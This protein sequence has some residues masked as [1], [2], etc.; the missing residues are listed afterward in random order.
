MINFY[1]NRYKY[2]IISIAIFAV[3]LVMGLIYGVKLDI[4]FQGGSITTYSYEGVL[5]FKKLENDISKALN[6]QVS[7]N[8]AKDIATG[9]N[10]VKIT[11][12][13]SESITLAE[14]EK[15]TKT[16]SEEYKN[17]KITYIDNMNVD[18][19]IGSEFFQKSLVAV[20]LASILI[21]IYVAVRFRKIGGWSAGAMAL[22]ALI[23]DVLIVFSV[24][25]ILRMPLNDNFIAVVLTVLGYS[26][27]DT[28]VI[29]DR[30]RENRR[31]LG[32][33]TKVVE[34]VNT[35]M[36]ET[37]SRT[38]NTSLSTFI[39]VSTVVVFSFIFNLESIRSFAI[40]MAAG[41]ISGAY[42]TLCIACTL[43]MMYKNREEKLKAEGKAAAR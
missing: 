5:D 28:I 15:M 16:L 2:F 42:S 31:I 23:H 8:G 39:A 41:I 7:V 13:S 26:I 25:V 40:P 4:Q 20:A 35:S 32:P 9:L 6:K 34:L 37:F 3:A 1:K 43:W 30:V 17:N 21:L 11:L 10:T 19:S 27:N 38:V 33:R 14:Q 24:F 18:P 36:N 12:A 29:Y 22:V